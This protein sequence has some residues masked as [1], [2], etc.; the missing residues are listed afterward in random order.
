MRFAN[1][2][3][4][5]LSLALAAG[6]G[7]QGYPTKPLR[8]IIPTAPG[9]NPDFIARPISQKMSESMKQAIVIDNRPG[10]AGIIGVE[11]VARAT[12]DGYTLL[13]G[14]IGHVAT[15]SALH[16]KLAFD[17]VKDFAP[18]SMLAAAPFA[19]FAHPSLAARSVQEL[20]ALAKARPGQLNYASFGIG[21]F[22]HFVTEAF[23]ASVGIKM[24]HVPY[25]GSAPAAVALLSG[26]VMLSFDALQATLPQVQAKRLYALAIGAARRAPIAPDI[27]T[28][29]EAGFPDVSA[30]AWFGLFAPANTPRDIVVKLHAEAV[31]AL[32]SPEIRDQFER[33]GIEPIGNTPEEFAATVRNDIA[34]FTRIAKDAGIRAE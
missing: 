29:A 5:A 21:S 22:T 28:F 33:A 11:F 13:F 32:S 10:A 14:A 20:V 1:L 24:V 23:N 9:G 25:K 15:P 12:P 26:E 27:P 7:A 2:S 4:I 17:A 19:L 3:I 30:S 8:I 34:K 31:K 6:V 18:I 16:A